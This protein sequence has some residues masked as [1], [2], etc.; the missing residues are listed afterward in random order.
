MDARVHCRGRG[1]LRPSLRQNERGGLGERR[2]A[3]EKVDGGSVKRRS[4]SFLFP[5]LANA[6]SFPNNP[7]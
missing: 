7:S 3:A 5:T 2:E 4:T 1:G 6:P